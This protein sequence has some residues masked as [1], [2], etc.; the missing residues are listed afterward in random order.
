MFNLP[1][2]LS[3][4]FHVRQ[5]WLILQITIICICF[6]TL[7]SWGRT[8]PIRNRNM[9]RNF[10]QFLLFFDFLSTNFNSFCLDT[11]TLQ[12]IVCLRN[13]NKVDFSEGHDNHVVHSNSLSYFHIIHVNAANEQ[14]ICTKWEKAL[15]NNFYNFFT[16]FFEAATRR[17]GRE[18]ERNFQYWIAKWILMK[19]KNKANLMKETR[20]H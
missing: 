3:F 5:R 13:R 1:F 8:F 4:N 11:C 14:E 17:N 2:F 12:F 20:R 6:G 16:D 19:T 10:I 9:A 7:S 15:E 18:I